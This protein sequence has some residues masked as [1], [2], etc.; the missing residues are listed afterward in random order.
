MEEATAAVELQQNLLV[1]RKLAMAWLH[2]VASM[3]IGCCAA[4]LP[5]TSSVSNLSLVS[6]AATYVCSVS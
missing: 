6:A 4:V 1:Y 2:T 3:T 5:S